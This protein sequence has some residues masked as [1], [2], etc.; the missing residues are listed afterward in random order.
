MMIPNRRLPTA[1]GFE[2]KRL[3]NSV[4]TVRIVKRVRWRNTQSVCFWIKRS[5]EGARK[6]GMF[7]K[8]EEEKK[9]GK[10]KTR[11][12]STI[13]REIYVGSNGTSAFAPSR[14]SL[15][16]YCINNELISY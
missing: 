9:G 14:Y 3:D 11:Q 8:R 5:S 2:P 10:R 4:S 7:E 12:T 15:S 6:R 13:L 1:W 16:S